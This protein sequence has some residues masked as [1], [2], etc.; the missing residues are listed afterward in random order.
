LIIA[1]YSDLRLNAE[2]V[3]PPQPP[4]TPAAIRPILAARAFAGYAGL[5][6]APITLRMERDI[7]THPL[8]TPDATLRQARLLEYQTLAGVLLLIGLL[9]WIRFGFRREPAIALSLIAFLIAYLP[10]SNLFSL[11]ATIAEHWLYV[12]S[13]WL[14]LAAAVS[15]EGFWERRQNANRRTWFSALTVIGASWLLFLGTRTWLRQGDWHDQRTFIERTIAAGGRSARMLM[16]LGNVEFAAGHPDLA[17]ARYREALKGAP[18][19]P[20][21]WLGY[22]SVLLRARDFP[23]AR[24]A[25]SHA[26]ISPLLAADC[27]SLRATLE[28]AESGADPGNLLH[29]ALDLAPDNWSLQKRYIEYLQRSQQLPQALSTLHQFMKRHLFRAESWRMLAAMLEQQ[30][31]PDYALQAWR[32]AAQR[33][34]RDEESRQALQRLA[35]KVQ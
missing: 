27:L 21:I 24:E 20:I 9:A 3:T 6:V 28:N 13:A 25:L 22:A 2:K 16:N 26:E 15:I 5:F 14:L 4:P 19:Q 31:Q 23:A 35:R 7:S 30:H 32:E 1:A 18:D 33:D 12:P 17:L 8:E 10:I 29:R 34:I 11:N